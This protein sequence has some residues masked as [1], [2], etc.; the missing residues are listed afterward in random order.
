MPIMRILISK[1]V[2]EAVLSTSGDLSIAE[3]EMC[4]CRDEKETG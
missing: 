2:S 4:G 3:E 1:E